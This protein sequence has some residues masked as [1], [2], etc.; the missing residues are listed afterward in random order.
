MPST[1]FDN[2]SIT[3]RAILEAD[4]DCVEQFVDHG[5]ILNDGERLASGM[6]AS[7]LAQGYNPVHPA[8]KFFG[9]GIGSLYLLF[10]QKRSHHIAHHRPA[11][12]RISA[13]LSS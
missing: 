2:S 5:L 6:E 3:A 7:L 11:V 4:G 1:D 12:A 13:E 10:T 8:S 9:L